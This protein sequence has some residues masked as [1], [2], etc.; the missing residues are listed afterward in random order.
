MM[1]KKTKGQQLLERVQKQKQQKQS[2]SNKIVGKKKK[3]DT[4]RRV[5]FNG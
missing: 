2:P 4:F 1:E 5:N 3:S